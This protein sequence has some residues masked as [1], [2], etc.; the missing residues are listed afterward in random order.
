MDKVTGRVVIEP[1]ASNP[2]GTL[3]LI[4]R[5]SKLA[6]GP[7][8]AVRKIEKSNISVEFGMNESHIMMGGVWPDQVWLTARLDE[9]GN[10]MTKGE[11]DWNSG[12][13]AHNIG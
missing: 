2:K 9:D 13:W 3:F 4:A 11:N 1:T 6:K 7:P 12:S 8:L 5:P 10:P